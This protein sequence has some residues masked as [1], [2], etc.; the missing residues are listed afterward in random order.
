[1]IKTFFVLW[2]WIGSG[3]SQTLAVD[4]YSTKAECEAAKSAIT[5][6]HADSWYGSSLKQNMVCLEATVKE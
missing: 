6:H 4:H 3:N 5:I 2:V 1:M